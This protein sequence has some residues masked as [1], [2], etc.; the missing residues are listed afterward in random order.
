MALEMEKVSRRHSINEFGA[1][2]MDETTLWATRDRARRERG[3][4]RWSAGRGGGRC[5]EAVRA[6][7]NLNACTRREACDASPSYVD[8]TTRQ[9]HRMGRVTV[10]DGDGASGIFVT[11]NP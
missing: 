3:G 10:G 7:D 8:R 11:V 2:G 1:E 9:G 4:F 5:C 6:V